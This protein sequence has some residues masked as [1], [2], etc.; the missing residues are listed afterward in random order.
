MKVLNSHMEFKLQF[1][2]KPPETRINISEDI[3]LIGSCFAEN[4]GI[5]LIENKFK[6]LI[7]PN[8]ILFNPISILN[9]IKSYKDEKIFSDND[10]L[11]FNELWHSWEHHGDFSDM[12]KGNV[13]AKI[14]TSQQ[15]AS[16][17]FNKAK[18]I[19]ITFGSAY[20]YELNDTKN[21]VANCHKFPQQ[22][23]TKRILSVDE[24]IEAFE[25]SGLANEQKQIILTVSPVRYL[26]DGLI[27]NNL[28]K[29]V[30]IQAVHEL[31]K[32]YNH[33]FYFPAYEIVIDELRDYRF[34]EDDFLHPN[35]LAVD[36]VW[37][38]F[39][40]TIFD[41]DTKNIGKEISKI[42][43]AKNHKPFNRLTKSHQ[44]FLENYLVIT[45][46][47]ATNYPFLHLEN[48]LNYFAQK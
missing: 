9:A 1:D 38:R 37:E 42:I 45:K 2:I 28:S 23:F 47:L 29:S 39:V 12:E 33:V 41:E 46:S 44:L 24:I 48:E 6:S 26:R 10:L 43:H 32:K 8:G 14:N 3:L 19:V 11:F 20:V 40:E 30:L 22:N 15:Q 34:F 21:I 17:H 13:I 7:N 27:E 36:Y 5:R 35:K 4:I 16:V 18:H 31:L 25:N